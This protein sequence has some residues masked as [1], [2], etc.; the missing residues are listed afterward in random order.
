ARTLR[1]AGFG[2]PG[3]PAGHNGRDVVPGFDVVDVGGLSPQSFLR[4]ERRSWPRSS[5]LSFQRSDERSLF[6]AD[7]S[8]RSFHQF[9]IELESATED[10][11]PQ[12]SIFARLF[13]GAVQAMHGQWILGTH[14][15][16]S[17]GRA[18]DISA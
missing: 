3:G 15:N 14:V 10:V 9:D 13:D 2:E 17:L 16:D 4:G 11:L 1:A 8:A 6:A 18:H 7:K 12:Q 5:G